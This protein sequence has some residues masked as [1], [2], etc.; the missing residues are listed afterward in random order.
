MATGTSSRPS[1]PAFHADDFEETTSYRKLSVLAI[2][3]LLLGLASPLCFGAPLLMTIPI[4]GTI[5][6]IL[7]LRHIA[8][9]GGTLAGNWAA[10]IGL[11]LCVGCAVAPFTRNFVLQTM[12]TQQ[13]DEFVRE[14]LSEIVAGKTEH[15]FKLSTD[16]LR[17]P[18][19]P[20]PGSKSPP[21]DPYTTF[22]TQ[23]MVK[24]LLAVGANP[25]IRAEESS[26]S[27]DA[28]SFQRVYVR[29]R[30]RI[31][32]KAGEAGAQPLVID[33]TAE[34]AKLPGED[35]SRWLMFA[36]EDPNKPKTLP[37]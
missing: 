26:G 19:P 15:A 20:E 8:A 35:A 18:P 3:A 27:Y 30:Y 36:L 10:V 14:W 5:I 12:R 7:A 21:I 31:T 13:A 11:V 33:V 25:E 6:S 28:P 9:S 16:S 24:A 34:R 4:A 23:P 37:Q 32:P 2:I 22:L 1:A 29:Q 17:R